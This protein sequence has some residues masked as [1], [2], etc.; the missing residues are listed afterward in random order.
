MSRRYTLAQWRAA[1]AATLAEVARLAGRGPL[2]RGRTRTAEE[3]EA[4]SRAAL[5]Q[6]GAR[7][8]SGRLVRLGPRRYELRTRA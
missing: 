3:R 7:A 8:A 4:L 1:R 5:A 2:R 6:V